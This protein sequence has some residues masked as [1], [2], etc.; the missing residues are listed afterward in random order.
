MHNSV[1]IRQNEILKILIQRGRISS[2]EL[3]E[4]FQVTT[5]TIRKDLDSLSKL[6]YVERRH[7][8]ATLS[9]TYR[10]TY[11]YSKSKAAFCYAEKVA[12]AQQALHY[13]EDHSVIYLDGGTTVC[14][15]SKL[16]DARSDLT[17]V[18]PSLLVADVLRNSK[19]HRLYLT[20]GIMNYDYDLLHIVENDS[21]IE[22]FRFTTAFFGSTGIRYH[23]G[24]TSLNYAEVV[25]QKKVFAQ[26]EFCTLLCDSS[27]FCMGGVYQY[28]NWGD[29][30]H[31]VTDS[32]APEEQLDSIRMHTDVVCVTI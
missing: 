30:T 14:E 6:G 13:V 22:Q 3:A 32:G 12:I 28:A 4:Y 24:P 27:K 20:G 11:V 17:V 9:E 15:L 26:S 16:L 2:S 25:I 18:T 19:K 5:E 8:G 1:S 10:Q 7:G 31:V 23:S 21:F 29:L